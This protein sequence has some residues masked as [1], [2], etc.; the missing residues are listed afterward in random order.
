MPLVDLLI[1]LHH[2]QKYI[3]TIFVVSLFVSGYTEPDYSA[4]RM[5]ILGILVVVI[6]LF[7]RCSR[8]LIIN[9]LIAR[10]K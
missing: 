4:L 5:N 10:G 6:M 2:S 8:K 9:H 1:L 3:S 7:S